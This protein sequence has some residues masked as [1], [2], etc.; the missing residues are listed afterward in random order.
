MGSKMRK[1]LTTAP[2][3]VAL[4]AQAGASEKTIPIDIVGDWCFD[5][6]DKNVSWYQLPSWTEGGHCTKILSINKYRF[7]GDN[8]HCEPVKVRL[9]KSVAPSGIGY[10]ATITSLCQSDGPVTAGELQT[11][12]FDRYKGNLSVTRL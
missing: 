4:I 2:V 5:I 10:T 6:Q 3:L 9:E 1:L 11:F 8:R 12:K 7:Y